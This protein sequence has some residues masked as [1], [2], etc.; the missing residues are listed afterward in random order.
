MSFVRKVLALVWKD[1]LSEL[2]T[3]E[4]LSS[5]LVF[6]LLVIVIFNFSFELRVD[7]VAQVAPGVLW[8]TFA[9]A[10]TLELTRSLA[11]EMENDCLDGLFLAPMDRGVIYLGKML[12]NLI[13]IT[14]VEALVLPIFSILFNLNLIRLPLLLAILL[15]T[16]G[17]AAVGTLLSAIAVNSRAREVMLPVLLFP[18]ILPV[19]IA[20]AKVTAGILDGVPLVELAQWLRFLVAFD[21]IFLVVSY[22]TF[23]FV[24]EG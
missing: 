21:I 9:F 18:I 14:A 1:V 3:R 4:M 20:A 13:F 19:V 15:G 2:R 8:V 23:D 12:G 7:N 11:T 16:L 6:A 24:V 10:S 17:F 5:M 22:L